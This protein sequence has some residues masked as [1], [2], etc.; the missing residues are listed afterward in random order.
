VHAYRGAEA[1]IHHEDEG[2]IEVRETGEGIIDVFF[3]SGAGRAA[4]RTFKV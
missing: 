3:L 2:L 1:P 4:R